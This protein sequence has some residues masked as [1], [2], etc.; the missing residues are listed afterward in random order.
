MQSADGVATPRSP[1]RMAG[2]PASRFA[3]CERKRNYRPKRRAPPFCPFL[4]TATVRE[5]SNCI[6]ANFRNV[7]LHYNDRERNAAR[8]YLMSQPIMRRLIVTWL[9]LCYRIAVPY[10]FRRHVKNIN[11][12]CHFTFHILRSSSN[13]QSN[14]LI[15]YANFFFYT[16]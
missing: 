1:L 15:L 4:P 11:T 7:S 5:R 10:R 8:A 9:L 2:R 3:I 12:S 16:K 13:N 14:L 6:N